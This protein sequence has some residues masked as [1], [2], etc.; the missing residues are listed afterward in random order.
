MSRGDH[1]SE[2]SKCYKADLERE[3][4]LMEEE[5]LWSLVG[6]KQLNRYMADMH[7]DDNDLEVKGYIT[8]TVYLY[9]KSTK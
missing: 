1:I 7:T 4:L 2:T 5:G 3:L 6:T 9:K 8:G